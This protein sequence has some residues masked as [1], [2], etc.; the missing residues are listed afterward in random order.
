MSELVRF[1]ILGSGA[2]ALL[3]ARA[4]AQAKGA[5]LVAIG[6]RNATTTT[7][8][9]GKLGVTAALDCDDLL[10]R[11]DVDAVIV[12]T[13][14]GTHAEQ[15]LRA[16]AAGKHVLVEKPIDVTLDRARALIEGC[17]TAGVRLGVVFQNRFLPHVALIR[18]AIQAGRLG[19]VILADGHVKWF[20]GHGY[21]QDAPWRGTRALD[22]GGALMNQ[23]IHTV[24]LVHHLAG[25]VAS[26]SGFTARLRHKSIE[27]EDT[28]VA[29]LRL[30]D[31]GCGVLEAATSVW[32]GFAR[33]LELHG[34][35]GSVVL[36]GNDV[37]V[38]S[39][40]GSG[41]E[42]AELAR[43]RGE[44]KVR[45]DGAQDPTAIDLTPHRLQLE[46]FAAAVRDDRSPAVDGEEGMRALE[47]V[48]AI[49]RSAASGQAVTLP[50][51]DAPTADG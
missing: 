44:E 51:R 22:G 6:G 15:G 37:P 47:I 49:Y 17:R 41:P 8:L 31:G 39:M 24:D 20:R 21:Y 5:K 45:S 23:A 38:W 18:G 4:L 34:E 19:R 12:C 16:A 30:V 26:V 35:R 43:L 9:A 3:H 1:G 36:E 33:R 48:L 50:L 25:P 42:E 10:A 40:E 7:E 2:V 14:S 46:D 11:K 29:A 13:P 32:P 27:C 28:A